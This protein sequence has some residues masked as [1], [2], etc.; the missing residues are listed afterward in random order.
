MIA[1]YKDSGDRRAVERILALHAKMLHHLVRRCANTS[2]EPY[3][4][5]LQ[6][7]RLGL[8]KAINGYNAGSGAQFSSYAYAMIDG[9]LRHQRGS[10]PPRVY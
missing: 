9:E 10:C 6:V 1:A 4:D 3:E 8:L 2:G 7:G 5:L